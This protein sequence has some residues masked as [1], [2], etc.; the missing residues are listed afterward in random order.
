MMNDYESQNLKGILRETESRFRD[1][2]E[3]N[4]KLRNEASK[5]DQY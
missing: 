4:R 2:E 3:E 1:L 5:K